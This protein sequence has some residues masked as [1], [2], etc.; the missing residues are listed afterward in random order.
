M[1]RILLLLLLP[2]FVVAQTKP[3]AKPVVK[4]TKAKT[5]TNIVAAPAVADGYVIKGEVKGF[6]NGTLV[7]LVNPQT[8]AT[9]A[10]TNL[11]KE[12]FELKGKIESPDIRLLMFN[13][14]TP[15]LNIFLDNSSITVKGS[16]TAVD[17]L[18]VS[19]SPAHKDYVAFTK[20]LDP[21][22]A[23][24]AQNAPYD[25]V[26]F[27]S[28][29]AASYDFAVKHT[30]SFITPFAIYRFYQ[31]TDD[32]NQADALFN[33]LT[34][35]VKASPMSAALAGLIAQAK[36]NATGYVLPD[37]TQ[38]DTSG[39]PVSLSSFRGKYVLIDFWASWCGPCRMENPNVVA[40]YN[41]F[42]DKNF[43][44]LG[45]SLD[46]PGKKDDW[47]R[48]IKDDNLTW[49]HVSDLQF[50]SNAVAQQFQIQSIPQNFLV[51][52]EGKLIAKN[53][54]G[55]ALERKLEQLLK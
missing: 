33:Q 11:S 8:G 41:R 28:A 2:G 14:Q 29:A 23:A 40:A 20:Q 24:F 47:M 38:P 18:E 55:A 31:A 25:S 4:T 45:V 21:Y 15:Y 35:E 27:K 13:R 36:Q 54:R 3:K 17:K 6:A 32:V 43:T 26:L 52:P 51:D 1:K 39:V 9:E 37:F 42:K 50:W 10:E 19:G 22:Q 5:K 7:M 34:P 12:K 44:V 16:S 46:R 48:A 53:L 30:A 49:T